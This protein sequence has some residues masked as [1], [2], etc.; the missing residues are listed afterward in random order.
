MEDDFIAK[1]EK[2]LDD[3]NVTP[4]Y[5]D[6]LSEPERKDKLT[7]FEV[8]VRLALGRDFDAF[9]EIDG[10]DVEGFLYPFFGGWFC[11]D[12][13]YKG[14]KY[15]YE[16]DDLDDFGENATFGPFPLKEIVGDLIF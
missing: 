14:E 2:W 3:H 4:E 10:E 6:Q 9:Y 12:A 5:V 1:T 11:I 16:T 15:H 7:V 8:Q 13:T